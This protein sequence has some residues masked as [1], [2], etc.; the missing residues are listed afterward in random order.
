MLNH[1]KVTRDVINLKSH[2]ALNIYEIFVTEC[3]FQPVDFFQQI[4]NTHTNTQIQ[5]LI[6]VFLGTWRST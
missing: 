1:S 3:R 2:V 4:V 5:I 6:V